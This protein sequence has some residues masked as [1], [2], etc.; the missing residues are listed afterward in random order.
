MLWVLLFV[1]ITVNS[2][3]LTTY[4]N[5]TVQ[6]GDTLIINDDVEADKLTIEDGAVMI[7][8]GDLTVNSNG[9]TWLDLAGILII[10][11][12]LII[13]STNNSAS[14]DVGDTGTLVVG[15]SYDIL[16]DKGTT[17]VNTGSVYMS[18]PSDFGG[19]GDLGDLLGALD[20]P[21]L[22]DVIED[23]ADEILDIAST[24]YNV[25]QGDISSDWTDGDN[26]STGVVPSA[27]DTIRID[28]G[29]D[30]E[31]LISS[32][33]V[34][35]NV[36]I[37]SGSVVLEPG[38]HLTVDNL[39]G[40]DNAFTIQNTIASPASLIVNGSANLDIN[41]DWTY[42]SL[43]L[44]YIGQCVTGNTIDDYNNSFASPNDYYL[45]KYSSQWDQIDTTSAYSFGVPLEGY[46]LVIKEDGT[47]SVKGLLNDADSY[48]RDISTAG[49]YLIANPYPSY[50]DI[51]N[52]VESDFG[53]ADQTIYV[54]TTV[55]GSRALVTYN[56]TTGYSTG[57]DFIA[58]GQSFWITVPSGATIF[59]VSED[60]KA[61]ASDALKN[62]SA[63]QNY[64][65]VGLSN[66]YYTSKM[67][68]FFRE[69]GSEEVSSLD[70]KLHYSTGTVP[71]V[72]SLK[73][74]EPL[75]V[76]LL[77]STSTY[78]SIPLGYAVEK[79]GN[80]SMEFDFDISN[81]SGN[82]DII[83]IDHELGVEVDL[84]QISSY[85]F[86][87]T[88]LVSDDRFEIEMTE[89][90]VSIST[91]VEDNIGNVEPVIYVTDNICTV[92]LS[93]IEEVEGS[94]PSVELFDM[95]GIQLLEMSIVSKETKFALP[96]KKQMYIV[97]VVV[98]GDSY[99]QKV[100]IE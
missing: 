88:G 49:D 52:F 33:Q 21:D 24:G 6:D 46:S 23:V 19:G 44:W 69:D 95:T 25:W 32:N 72:Y 85:S 90:L 99:L 43:R 79:E 50:L 38:V 54:R 2:Y 26:W 80:T 66:D 61:H 8:Y 89:S 81:L 28:S 100:I 55:D 76:S 92:E 86:T 36:Y 65:E 14:A 60:L 27:N 45:Y 57:V 63:L 93:S 91:D 18:D 58:P 67:A 82:Y 74:D 17:E 4:N 56:W 51:G 3:G 47:L 97:K 87:P 53:G 62:V 1:L 31:L 20:D 64:I 75:V 12:D 29:T 48:T 77:P 16:G 34:L 5:L 41:V 73:E 39:I 71:N 96:S 68:V 94:N 98:N 30:N 13:D 83:L 7:I 59:T 22:A 70:S 9:S 15:G 10:T 35:G 37:I 40:I 42:T 78:S 11:G 84:T